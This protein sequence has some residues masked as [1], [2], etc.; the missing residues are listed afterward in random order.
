MWTQEKTIEV[1]NFIPDRQPLESIPFDEYLDVFG[2][3]IRDQILTQKGFKSR[4]AAGAKNASGAL[5]T[6]ASRNSGGNFTFR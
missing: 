6:P 2:K 1:L 4:L 3:E 5:F